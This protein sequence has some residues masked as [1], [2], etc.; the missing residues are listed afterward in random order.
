MLV[1]LVRN[2]IDAIDAIAPTHR[3]FQPSVQV[4]A[5][6]Q[7]D[8]LVIDV[9]DNGNGIP[10]PQLDKVFS[11]GFS[12]KPSGTGL[13][14]HSAAN[15]VI[16]SGGRIEAQSNGPGQGTTIRSSWPLKAMLPT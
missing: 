11:P 1:N 6:I 14:L 13:G 4:R 12:T 2:C 8:N 10:A 7:D 3:R 9:T 5:Y 15:Y 16:G